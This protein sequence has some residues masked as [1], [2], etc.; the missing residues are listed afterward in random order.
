MKLFNLSAAL[1]TSVGTVWR[2]RRKCVRQLIHEMKK[3]RHVES[4][5]VKQDDFL[6]WTV[7]RE[8][9][10]VRDNSDVIYNAEIKNTC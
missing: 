2:V 7:T 5:A 4:T 8:E 9:S 3:A 1:K 10:W 6:V